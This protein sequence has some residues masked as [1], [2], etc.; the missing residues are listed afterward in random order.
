[1]L[2]PGSITFKEAREQFNITKER[3]FLNWASLSPLPRAC[4]DTLSSFIERAQSTGTKALNELIGNFALRSVELSAK[5]MQTG[6]EHI[7][8][9]GDSTTY[10]VQLALDSIGPVKGQNIVVGELEFPSIT[11]SLMKWKKKGVEL[12][13]LPTE[14]GAYLPSQLE[15]VVDEN[16]AAVV[17]SSV[18]WVNGY[19]NNIS[20]LSKVIAGHSAYFIVDAVQHLGTGPFNAES[21]GA[22]FICAGSQKWLTNP[23]GS[24]IMFVGSR[25]IK[26][27]EPPY[28]GMNNIVPPEEGWD[29]FYGDRNRSILRSFNPFPDARKF[30]PGGWFNVAGVVSLV[31]SL[32]IILSVGLDNVRKNTLRLLQLLQE[33]FP[34]SSAN[35]S[36][37]KHQSSISLLHFRNCNHMQ[38]VDYL[39]ANGVDV[40]Y[41]GGA[42]I[43]G[44][45]VALHYPNNEEDVMRF[46][47]L[48]RKFE[49]IDS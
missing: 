36:E 28:V 7:S 5:L 25:P 11:S 41:R 27:L 10:A 35:I 23:L 15:Q 16:T 24:A 20:E 31:A 46:T 19:L 26:E 40:S 1:M 32:E 48:L 14:V 9:P 45:R 38:A 8:I 2:Y 18:N 47:E 12:R 17:L 21:S 44:I 37:L 13:I 49:G 33:Q 29:R 4:A 34:G 22:D 42:G 6:M 30:N 3:V 43:E 39:R